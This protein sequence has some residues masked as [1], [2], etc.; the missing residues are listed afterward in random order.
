ML[1]S[2]AGGGDTS[3]IRRHVLTPKAAQK[4]SRTIITSSGSARQ[5]VCPQRFDLHGAD[6]STGLDS[7]GMLGCHVSDQDAPRPSLAMDAQK[8]QWS[9]RMLALSARVLQ[10][11]KPKPTALPKRTMG[12]SVA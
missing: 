3:S 8:T 7:N 1:P 11:P 4:V 6:R 2:C 10:K 5:W 12:I 9:F